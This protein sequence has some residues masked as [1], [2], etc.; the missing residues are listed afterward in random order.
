[1][2]H[3]PQSTSFSRRRAIEHSKELRNDA[4]MEQLVR[5]AV[6]VRAAQPDA[7]RSGRLLTGHLNPRRAARAEAAADQYL[8]ADRG[9]S[10]HLLQHSK[11]PS[12]LGVP[13]ARGGNTFRSHRAGCRPWPALR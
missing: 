5:A 9:H 12:P 10:L 6:E 4:F 13:Q 2:A 3:A 11:N 7:T 1:M 8:S